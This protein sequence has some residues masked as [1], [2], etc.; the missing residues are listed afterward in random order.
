M[1]T[2]FEICKKNGKVR[3]TDISNELDVEKPSVTFAIKKLKNLKLVEHEKYEDITLTEKGRIKANQI[4]FRHNILYRILHDFLGTPHKFAE[5]D[6][7]RIEHVLSEISLDRLSL[8]VD[9]FDKKNGIDIGKW[10]KFFESYV[11][12]AEIEKS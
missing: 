8:F 5:K 12:K 9:L 6:A 1:K 4:L 10:Q 11:K 7:H 3:I 2:I